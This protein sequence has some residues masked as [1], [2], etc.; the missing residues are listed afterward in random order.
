MTIRICHMSRNMKRT[1]GK[2]TM[3]LLLSVTTTTKNE[4]AEFIASTN[5]T[6]HSISVKMYESM[7]VSR[8]SSADSTIG[9][10]E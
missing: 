9:S 6:M 7:S 3:A 1:T 2:S 8:L 5:A 10:E 4:Y